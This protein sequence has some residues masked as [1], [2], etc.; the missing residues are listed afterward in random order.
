MHGFCNTTTQR[1][2]IHYSA[3]IDYVYGNYLQFSSVYRP[4]RYL[5]IYK[6][7]LFRKFYTFIVIYVLTIII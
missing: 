6:F 2:I 7:P 3:V 5:L 1:V 4:L